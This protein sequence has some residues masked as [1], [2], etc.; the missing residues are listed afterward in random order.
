MKKQKK[1]RLRKWIPCHVSD[2]A[3]AAGVAAAVCGGC[4]AP[5]SA[6]K[7]CGHGGTSADPG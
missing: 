7:L 5:S 6:G 3:A 4:R 1:T 2:E